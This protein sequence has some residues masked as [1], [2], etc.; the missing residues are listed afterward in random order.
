[1]RVRWAR[2]RRSHTVPAAHIVALKCRQ[3]VVCVATTLDTPPNSQPFARSMRSMNPSRDS[4][5]NGSS[6]CGNGDS[7]PGNA[8][9]VTR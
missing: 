9:T 1:L 6:T 8:I 5:G 3:S 2:R 7:V 4:S